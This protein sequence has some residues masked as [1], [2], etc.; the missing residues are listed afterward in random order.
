MPFPS[1]QTHSALCMPSGHGNSPL[2]PSQIFVEA[3]KEK[4]AFIK[5]INDRDRQKAFEYL[6]N[7]CEQAASRSKPDC[8]VRYG[9]NV[10]LFNLISNDRHHKFYRSAERAAKDLLRERDEL[11]TKM[12]TNK[13]I[14]ISDNGRI[15]GD[16]TCCSARIL[17]WGFVSRHLNS[18]GTCGNG[19]SG[20]EMLASP[21]RKKTRRAPRT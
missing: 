9:P 7:K 4:E 18:G 17:S 5:K 6:L 3:K 20:G 13:G 11:L 2:N 8:L 15:V 19:G 12:L 14:S 16:V 21:K 10:S 1:I